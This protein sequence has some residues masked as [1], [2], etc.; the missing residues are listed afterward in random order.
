MGA[1][2]T[3]EILAMVCHGPKTEDIDKHSLTASAQGEYF[4]VT[5][6]VHSVLWSTDTYGF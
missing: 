2:C 6:R 1:G 5:G 3:Q 4:S